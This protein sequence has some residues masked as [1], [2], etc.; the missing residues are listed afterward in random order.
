[1]KTFENYLEDQF[2]KEYHGTDD[3]MFDKFNAWVERLDTSEVIEYGNKAVAE[4]LASYER[5][6]AL[7]DKLEKLNS[8]TIEE[9]KRVQITAGINQIRRDELKTNLSFS[10]LNG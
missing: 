3:D 7:A 5:L 6:S 9:L 4:L 2:E 8:E 1:M 10:E